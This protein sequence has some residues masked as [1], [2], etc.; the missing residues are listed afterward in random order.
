MKKSHII[1]NYYYKG[2]MRMRT[3]CPWCG[4]KNQPLNLNVDNWLT[5]ISGAKIQDAFPDLTAAERETIKTGICPEC[6]EDKFGG[7]D[8]DI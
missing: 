2:V 3:K 6:W 8:D 5:Y 1:E 7:D 4:K